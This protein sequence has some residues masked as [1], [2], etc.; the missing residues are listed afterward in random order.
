M[1]SVVGFLG[2]RISLIIFAETTSS[3]FRFEMIIESNRLHQKIKRLKEELAKE[4]ELRK[5][6]EKQWKMLKESVATS[7]GGRSQVLEMTEPTN[8]G[9]VIRTPIIDSASK[10]E[11]LPR[12]T[13]PAFTKLADTSFHKSE[14][15]SK[16]LTKL[17]KMIEE[18]RKAEIGACY[19]DLHCNFPIKSIETWKNAEPKNLLFQM[20]CQELFHRQGNG[21]PE[22]SWRSYQELFSALPSHLFLPD[23]WM[24]DIIKEF[25]LR[26]QNESNCSATPWNKDSVVGSLTTL[27][28]NLSSLQ[29]LSLIGLLQLYSFLEDHSAISEV[30]S[31]LDVVKAQEL[32]REVFIKISYEIGFAY[33]MAPKCL[34]ASKYFLEVLSQL[35]DMKEEKFLSYIKKA[36]KC[37]AFCVSNNAKIH[38]S[39]PK[40]IASVIESTYKLDIEEWK[41]GKIETF[42]RFFSECSPY[43]CELSTPECKAQNLKN[44]KFCLQRVTTWKPM[45]NLKG[46]LRIRD[47]LP[48]EVV[49][50][51]IMPVTTESDIMF[52]CNNNNGLLR[53]VNSKSSGIE[54]VLRD[55]PNIHM[56]ETL[57]LLIMQ[58]HKILRK[59]KSE[60]KVLAFGRKF[61][62]VLK[63]I[64]FTG[65][66]NVEDAICYIRE[67]SKITMEAANKLVEDHYKS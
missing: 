36:Q 47:I 60:E 34:E 43:I 15:V 20:L 55:F 33:L 64:G 42:W 38:K 57:T 8:I 51:S 45:R 53:L 66:I 35:K 5:E 4:K 24:Y 61:V 29:S 59:Q 67:V 10:D 14:G 62:N 28:S 50:K 7:T 16:L 3:I 44:I 27:F 58:Y 41:D 31:R 18:Q 22:E 65:N 21:N 23:V 39:I 32:D 26:F 40:C 6:A 54:K 63:A 30:L 9:L 19:K 56:K 49:P 37:L 2:R 52:F 11:H 1:L 12:N 25:V 46:L 48:F 17:A 13:L